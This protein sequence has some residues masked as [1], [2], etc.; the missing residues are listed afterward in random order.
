MYNFQLKLEFPPDRDDTFEN[1]IQSPENRTCAALCHQF[2]TLQDA[3]PKG[4]VIHGPALCGKTHLLAAMGQVASRSVGSASAVYL[5]C[6]QLAAE[7]RQ[8]DM[9]GRLAEYVGAMERAVFLTVDRLEAAQDEEELCNLVFNL[10]NEVTGKPNGRFAAASAVSPP[11]WRFPDWLSTRL[12]W[13]HVAELRPVGDEARPQV[14]MKMAADMRMVLPREAALWLVT[15]LPRDPESQWQALG[16]ID[17]L[18]LT[19]G[20]KISIPLIKEAVEQVDG[21]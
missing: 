4:L 12:L 21:Q 1:F 19:K 20:R 7:G 15:R 9:Y 16:R 17:R 11:Q 6:A 5:D 13:G 2:S 3:A 8:K 14:L 18:S 10:Y